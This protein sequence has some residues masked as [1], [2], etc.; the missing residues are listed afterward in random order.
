MPWLIPFGSECTPVAAAVLVLMARRRRLRPS[1]AWW[2]EME[3]DINTLILSI[4]PKRSWQPCK[5]ASDTCIAA[6]R[7]ILFTAFTQGMQKRLCL[8]GWVAS[9]KMFPCF[10][11]LYKRGRAETFLALSLCYF[12]L[13]LSL[14][15]RNCTQRFENRMTYFSMLVGFRSR[16]R[17]V[18][19]VCLFFSTRMVGDGRNLA[20]WYRTVK[21]TS[22]PLKFWS[23]KNILRTAAVF[24]RS[25]QSLM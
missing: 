3:V 18:L 25:D 12:F 5:Q 16:L 11:L 17:C 13:S 1:N 23:A 8:L 15:W 14:Y 22:L 20:A 6:F 4:R 9:K 24:T 2:N 7:R 19:F 10:F 21:C